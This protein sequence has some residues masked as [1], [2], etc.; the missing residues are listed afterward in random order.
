MNGIIYH[1]QQG[2]QQTREVGKR[3]IALVAFICVLV[4]VAP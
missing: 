2:G 1:D 3:V 4:C